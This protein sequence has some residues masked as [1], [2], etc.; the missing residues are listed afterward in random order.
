M[1]LDVKGIQPE[2]PFN[3][4]VHQSQVGIQSRQIWQKIFVSEPFQ[5]RLENKQKSHK[6]Y[7][8]LEYLMSKNAGGQMDKLRPVF[9]NKDL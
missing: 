5:I 2:C 8:S 7:G 1:T 3:P 9:F 6:M 4:N